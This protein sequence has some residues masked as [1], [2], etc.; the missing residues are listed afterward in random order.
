MFFIRLVVSV[1]NAQPSREVCRIF[2]IHYPMNRGA[3]M[4]DIK[5]NQM[6]G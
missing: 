4:I 3:T 5:D 2:F 1:N 6:T